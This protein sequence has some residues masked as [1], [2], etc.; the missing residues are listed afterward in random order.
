[1]SVALPRLW[2]L[3]LALA[4]AACSAAAS[5]P[6]PAPPPAAP[7][8]DPASQP[9]VPLGGACGASFGECDAAGYC[10]HVDD[11]CGAQVAGVCT[12]RP[13]GCKRDCPGVC[14]CD[15]RFYCNACVA[16]AR[17]VAV[18]HAGR[19]APSDDAPAPTSPDSVLPSEPTP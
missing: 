11:A 12:Q 4:L 7:A 18:R 17:G 13:R 10:A 1:M 9:G 6:A 3:A 19:C 15:G 14:G 16:R 5:A 8:Q 2:L